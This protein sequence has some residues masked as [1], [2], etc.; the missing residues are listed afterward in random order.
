MNFNVVF[1]V[2]LNDPKRLNLAF[3]NVANYMAFLDETPGGS[4]ASLVMLGNGPVVNLFAKRPEN[5]DLEARGR[6]LM[7]N[8][9]SIRLC[10]NAL[11][12]FEISPEQVWEGCTVVPAGI[13]ELV[14][15][16]NEG[17]CYLKP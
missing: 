15:L 11:R 6:Q 14:K 2:D 3:D 13:P 17:Y 8:G 7:E 5:A 12:K 4:A 10:S 1:H 16:Q 9:L